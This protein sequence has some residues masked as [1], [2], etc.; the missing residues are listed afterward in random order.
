MTRT[1]FRESHFQIWKSRIQHHVQT[2]LQLN[3]TLD[4]L[5]DEMY[6]LWFDETSMTPTDV[7]NVIVHRYFNMI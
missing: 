2:Q 1:S 3:I 4:E 6:R 5:P 7:A